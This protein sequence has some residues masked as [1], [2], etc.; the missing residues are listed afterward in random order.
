MIKWSDKNRSYDASY[1][2]WRWRRGTNSKKRVRDIYCGNELMPAL[3]RG[4]GCKLSH[5]ERRAVL[6]KMVLMAIVHLSLH[7]R[8]QKSKLRVISLWVRTGPNLD[9]IKVQ[10]P[11]VLNCGSQDVFLWAR[12]WWSP[13]A[14]SYSLESGRLLRDWGGDHTLLLVPTNLVGVDPTRSGKLAKSIWWALKAPWHEP[15]HILPSCQ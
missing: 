14:F 5:C 12:W 10:F 3:T 4:P 9:W 11:V 6:I 2:S 1:N 7:I 13:I 8:H 15:Q